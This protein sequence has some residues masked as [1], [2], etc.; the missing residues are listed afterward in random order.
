ML[1]TGMCYIILFAFEYFL[2]FPIINFFK[3]SCNL[4]AIKALITSTGENAMWSAGY[5]SEVRFRKNER[6]A[7]RDLKG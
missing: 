3:C 2:I 7:S 6:G 1:I 5:D 4:A